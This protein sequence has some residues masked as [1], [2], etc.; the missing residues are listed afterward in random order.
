LQ[1][2]AATRLG[3]RALRRTV[4]SLLAVLAV[5]F[6]A[7][8][9]PARPAPAPGVAAVPPFEPSLARVPLDP[10]WDLHG[11][12]GDYR[13]NHFHA[14]LD[15]GT[16]GRV[17][18][19]V[20]APLSGWI[21][22]VRS[23]GVGY[24]RSLYLHADDGRLLVFGHLDAFS[25]PLD[26]FVAQAQDSSGQ[27]EQDLWPAVDQFRVAAGQR[28][29][30]SGESGAGGPHLHFEIRR[31]DMAYHPL[32]SGIVLLDT[33]APTISRLTLEPLDEASYVQRGAAPF[34]IAPGPE[35]ETL[36]VIGRVRAVVGVRVGEWKG[37]DR[38]VP[39]S[40]AIEFGKERVECRFDSVSWA[41]D[42]VE[43]DYVYDTGR[44]VG[45][46]GLVLWAPA[47]FRPRVLVT[48]APLRSEAGTLVVR[49][50]DPPRV[51]TITTRDLAGRFV[52]R[53]V[54]LRPPARG[55][56][57]PDTASVGGPARRDSTR[58]FDLA[59]L[60][61][62][63]LRVGFRGAAAGSRRIT[64]GGRP[65]SYRLGAWTA[66]V[67]LP[68]GSSAKE[69][70]LS[71][72]IAGR[73]GEGREWS[74]SLDVGVWWEPWGRWRDESAIGW[75][76]D[77]SAAFEPGPVLRRSEDQA[78]EAARELALRSPILEL[79]PSSRPLRKPVRLEVP[80]KAGSRAG[81]YGDDGTGWS[82]ITAAM[83]S[84]SGHR[85][86]ETRHLGR[87]AM[88]ADTLAPRI[89]ARRPAR[90][91]VAGPYSRWALEARLVD[92]GSGV[93]ARTSHFEVDGRPVP[94][95]WD[96]EEG[97]LRWR[98]RRAP[99]RGTHRFVV[100]ATDR[101][102]NERRLSGRFALR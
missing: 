65:A 100:V 88:F 96:A 18:R 30:W 43:S 52:E 10:P 63:H 16:G 58:E 90:R 39:W 36:M 53:R 89:V 26:A 87:F 51:L 22:R 66:V 67:S 71:L 12:F 11:G 8:P 23:S 70:P 20:Y 86:G 64:I 80:T 81:L 98:P 41:T 57:G 84:G 9:G 4:I 15:L 74:R 76:M 68:R 92:E 31:V 33:A 46:M 40:T 25:G 13:S 56:E 102:G 34:S 1:R 72:R 62:S 59:L 49:R 2:L 44:V 21:E 83:D 95:E 93:G 47:G 91:A 29:A 14:G 61:G 78:P 42:M 45:D 48:S 69:T 55:E 79:A 101:A 97:L 6:A 99:V 82:W 32:R 75:S 19:P 54:V 7:A 17:G 27:Y 3:D 50:G 85:I 60:P 37:V 35:P 5:A 24:G 38:M 73:N 77:R 94:S 28:I